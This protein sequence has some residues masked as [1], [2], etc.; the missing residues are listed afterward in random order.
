MTKYPNA[1]FPPISFCEEKIVTEDYEKKRQFK[2]D[3]KTFSI[4]TILNKPKQNVINLGD[5][6]DNLN[7]V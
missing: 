5:S 4:R 7:E 3:I 2:S 6:K 1:G